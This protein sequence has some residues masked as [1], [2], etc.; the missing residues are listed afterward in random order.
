MI[1]QIAKLTQKTQTG[2]TNTNTSHTA[3]LNRN[4]SLKIY[5]KSVKSTFYDAATAANRIDV[6][7][8][9]IFIVRLALEE[10]KSN[11]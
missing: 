5:S 7:R 8:L 10:F 4:V 3:S 1:I 11:N 9:Y 6:G 2:R